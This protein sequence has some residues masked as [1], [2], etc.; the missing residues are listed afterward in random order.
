MEAKE[1]RVGILVDFNGETAKVKQILEHEVVFKCGD[2]ELFENLKGIPLTEK[3]LLK[4]FGF[5][6]EFRQNGWQAK[7]ED[8]YLWRGQSWDYWEYSTVNDRDETGNEADVR[9]DFVHQL[10]N[11][12][13]V[14]TGEEL[15]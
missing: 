13:Y 2:S 10:Q 6:I 7:K 15:E 1:L 9:L 12:Y 5:E 11:L 8:F 4:R 14:L 3:W